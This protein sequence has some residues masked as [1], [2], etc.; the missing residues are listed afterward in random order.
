M[1]SPVIAEALMQF[2]SGL[3]SSLSTMTKVPIPIGDRDASEYE[4]TILE[5][6]GDGDVAIYDGP[7]Q[8][9][10][11]LH[12]RIPALA[13]EVPTRPI[14]RLVPGQRG[15]LYVYVDVANPVTL[16]VRLYGRAPCGGR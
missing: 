16:L 13:S 9:P 2:G 5:S 7:T 6:E 1:C 10:P 8:T 12:L 4:V 11:A 15:D 14:R 3:G